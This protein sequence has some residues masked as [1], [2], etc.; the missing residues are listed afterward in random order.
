M[1]QDWVQLNIIPMI[2]SLP[3]SITLNIG[4]QRA[5]ARI[6]AIAICVVAFILT[7]F[8]CQMTLGKPM[9]R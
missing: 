5:N 1:G 8:I 9:V 2:L 3:D 7:D 6:T 4:T